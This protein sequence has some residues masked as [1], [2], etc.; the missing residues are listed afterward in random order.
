MNKQMNEQTNDGRKMLSVFS[1][2][3][4]NVLT[5]IGVCGVYPMAIYFLLLYAV[6]ITKT[7]LGTT[8]FAA[9]VPEFGCKVWG[10]IWM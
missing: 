5:G 10:D 7:N 6:A 9:W 2:A 4:D 1:V 8:T 3:L